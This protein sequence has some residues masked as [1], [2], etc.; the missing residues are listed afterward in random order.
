MLATL[1]ERDGA[2]FLEESSGK[3]AAKMQDSFKLPP[4]VRSKLYDEF[5]TVD[6][7]GSGALD[8]GELSDLFSRLALT[9]SDKV[10]R[11]AA[12]RRPAHIRRG[13]PTRACWD[14]VRPVPCVEAL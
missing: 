6:A 13:P 1:W 8:A 12:P 3:R 14:E 10:R 5:C 4:E 9:V 2:R 7:D 11:R